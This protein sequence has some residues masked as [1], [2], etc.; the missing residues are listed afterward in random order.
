M[1]FNSWK[2]FKFLGRFRIGTRMHI[3]PWA[4][5][6]FYKALNTTEKEGYSEMKTLTKF[7]EFIDTCFY[8]KIN[9]CSDIKSNI[10]FKTFFFYFTESDA[11]LPVRII[12]LLTYAKQFQAIS[13]LKIYRVNFLFPVTMMQE[14]YF[15]ITSINISM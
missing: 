8:K 6:W 7:H 3:R 15:C 11:F 2:L 13:K 10:K 9:L 5:S 1:Y 12:A 4:H 14:I